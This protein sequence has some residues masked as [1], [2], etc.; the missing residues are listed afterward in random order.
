VAQA[1]HIDSFVVANHLNIT[2]G[3][4]RVVG[5]IMKVLKIQRHFTRRLV[6]AN[7]ANQ[8]AIGRLKMSGGAQ[9]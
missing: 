4:E 5:G 1:N 3:V 2:K 6:G 8:G 9:L 7:R